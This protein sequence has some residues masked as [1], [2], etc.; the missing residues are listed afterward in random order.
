MRASHPSRSG[1][2]RFYT[3]AAMTAEPAKWRDPQRSDIPADRIRDRELDLRDRLNIVIFGTETPEGRGFDITL[4]VLIV[5]SVL[6]VV[7]DSVEDLHDQSGAVFVILEWIFTVV[8]TIEY[9]LRI[10]SAR[11]RAR[12]VFSFFGLVDLLA[13]L[14]TYL[15]SFFPGAQTLMAIRVLR[16]LRVF[17]V[18]KIVRML[19]EAHA[20][21]RAIRLS[22]PKISV[23]LGS[24]LIIVIVIGTAMHLIEGAEHGFSSIPVSMYWAIVTLTTVGY[25][26]IAPVT[27]VGQMLAATLMIM[28]YGIIAVP[29]GIVS[30]ELVHAR[31]EELDELRC[32]ACGATQHRPDAH[33]C[34]ICGTELV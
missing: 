26:D 6:V 2:P 9:G 12:Y 28:G 17:R 30:A 11:R 31:E 4:L 16:L 19:G 7:L 24:V 32:R 10:Y 21:M 29:T 20:L 15:V 8:F 1:R 23:F 3:L 18:F 34:R 13:I 22:L 14:P 33:F 25:G 5:I 27:P